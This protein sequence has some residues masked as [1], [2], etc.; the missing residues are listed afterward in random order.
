MNDQEF[1]TNTNNL[2]TS[3]WFQVI[4]STKYKAFACTVIWFP[5][6]DNYNP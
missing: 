1:L 5:E 4:I 6:N 2:H 3:T